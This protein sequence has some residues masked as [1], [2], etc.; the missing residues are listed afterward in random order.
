MTDDRPMNARLEVVR[1][2]L[3]QRGQLHALRWWDERSATQRGELLADLESIPWHLLD[4]LIATHV[5]HRPPRHIPENIEPAPVFPVEPAPHQRTLY[6]EARELGRSLIREGKVAAFTVAGGQ[7]TRLGFD[8][9]KGALPVTPVT[10]KSLFQLFAETILAT[11]RKHA[12]ATPW[13]I[14]TS[15]A[16]HEATIR[17]LEKHQ[18]FG[19]PE[20]DV[21]PFP[22]GMLPAF[23][24]QGRLLLEAK[25]RL[26]ISPDGHGGSL[27]A[28]VLS[29]A[30][31]EMR[32]RGIE[33]IS[34]FQVDNP[35]VKPFDPLFIGLHSKTQ[36]EMSTKVT[37]KADD[38]E[39]VGNVCMHDGRVTMIEY[40][41]LPNELATAQNQDGSRRFNAANLAIHLFD[42]AFVDRVI[43]ESFQLP[44]R[45][46]E[47]VVPFVDDSGALV[48]PTTPNAVKLET[49]VFD[50]LPLAKNPLVLEVDRAEE[51]SPI[52]NPTG[53]D[54][55]ESAKR[56]QI[57]RAC[58]WLEKAGVK[59]AR[60][61]TGAELTVEIS[62]LAALEADDLNP[63]VE[64]VPHVGG[65][66]RFL[67]G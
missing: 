36:S 16:N 22:Q 35:L 21:I 41:E 12:V 46:A 27:K 55:L 25:H 63:S 53:V 10:S 1:E 61:A 39:R 17:F 42:V 15:P 66:N 20:Q 43:S 30:L 31:A 3:S 34:Y 59:L 26:A 65:G 57:A 4:P 37:P 32:R 54:S 2:Q 23:D 52:K 5:R 49:F 44:F 13:Y 29:G 8:G 14:M 45:R 7:G 60:P 64:I 18:F 11:R 19:L 50:V 24:L 38:F 9:P 6:D 47:K 67:I 51:F 58:R 56:D 33:I 28:M 62:P 48:T 40:S